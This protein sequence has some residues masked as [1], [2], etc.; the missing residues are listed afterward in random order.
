[1]SR[2]TPTRASRALAAAAA[3]ALLAGCS[4]LPPTIPLIGARAEKAKPAEL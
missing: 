2:A 3:L 4:N 1:M